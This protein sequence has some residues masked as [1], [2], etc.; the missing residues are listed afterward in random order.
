MSCSRWKS[1]AITSGSSLPAS[2]TPTRPRRSTRDSRTSC[3]VDAGTITSA[4]GSGGPA[5][6]AAASSNC[7]VSGTSC[8]FFMSAIHAFLER[9]DA[10]A[11][12]D[13]DETFR[14][15]VAIRKIRF[16]ELIDDTGH[17]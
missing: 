15:R 17:L 11:P 12:Y 16:D 14:L 1:G 5:P 4:A 7:Q 2:H 8:R 13:I 3:H 6:S 9:F 10:D